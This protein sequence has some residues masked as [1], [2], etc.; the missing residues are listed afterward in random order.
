ML[1][2]RPAVHHQRL[3]ARRRAPGQHACCAGFQHRGR[4]P[5][6]AGTA[7]SGALSVGWTDDAPDHATRTCATLEA[8]ADLATVACRNAE[9]YEHVQHAA[10]TDALT[11][12]LNH[13]AM[14]VRMREE[15]ARARRDGDAARPA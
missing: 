13:G 11:G 5:D 1:A 14:Q 10:R 8:I 4:R 3:P 15:I 9:A 6:G 7:S 12:L 2:H